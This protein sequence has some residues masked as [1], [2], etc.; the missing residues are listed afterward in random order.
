[1]PGSENAS[2]NS[3]TVF[4]LKSAPL[5]VWTKAGSDHPLTVL[6]AMLPKAAFVATPIIG[7]DAIKPMP[8]VHCM[9]TGYL[10]SVCL[11][12]A[13]TAKYLMLGW[14]GC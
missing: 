11:I 2:L 10:L 1:M 4:I 5:S 8:S 7:R 14:N 9:A 6:T 3:N 12:A 13:L